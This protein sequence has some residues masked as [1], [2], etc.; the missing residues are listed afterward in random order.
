MKILMADD[1]V[2]SR[3]VLQKLLAEYGEVHT[4]ES[5]AQAA[6]MFLEAAKAGAHYGLLCVDYMLPGLNGLEVLAAA[7]KAEEEFPPKNPEHRFR[8]VFVTAVSDWESRREFREKAGYV[9]KP[10]TAEKL[11][12]E[13]AKLGLARPAAGG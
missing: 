8:T 5:G 2:I 1:N 13:L 10:V 11:R 4:A 12:E 3:L 6:E 7:R 9:A